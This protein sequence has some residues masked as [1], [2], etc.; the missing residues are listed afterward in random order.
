M[1]ESYVRDERKLG[2]GRRDGPAQEDGLERRGK[3]G[4][5]VDAVQCL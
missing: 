3:Y 2:H 4:G 5:W 1:G